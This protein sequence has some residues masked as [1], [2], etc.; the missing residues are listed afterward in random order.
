VIDDEQKFEI[1]G[2]DEIGYYEVHF[3]DEYWYISF[4]K[5]LNLR[6]AVLGAIPYD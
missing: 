1:T 5:L 6:D 4:E 2:P 3:C